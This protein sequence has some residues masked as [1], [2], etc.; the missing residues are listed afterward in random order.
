M[1][2]ASPAR[3]AAVRALER[4]QA[5]DA[6]ADVALECE[7]GGRG[8]GPRDAALATE[9]TFGT[10][11]WQRYL[12]WVLAP[13]SHRA[14]DTLDLR[15]RILLR[16]AAYQIVFLDR[17]PAF[18]AV[19]DAVTLAR[20]RAR[21]GIPEFVNAVLRAFARRG[22][23]EREPKLPPDPVEALATRWSYPTWLT[24]RL[25][26]R[27]GEDE[28]LALM[29]AMNERPPAT[30]RVNTLRT[31][32]EELIARLA[33]DEQLA[34]RP[35]R[36]APE[37]VTVEH[38]GAPAGWRSFA[39]GAFAVQDEASMLVSRLLGPRPGETVADVCAAPGTKT[40]HLAQLMGNTGHIV[41]FD[42]QPARLARVTEAS[43][44]LGVTIVETETGAVEE[45]A[46]A[47]TERCDAVL[48]D[49]PCSNLGVLRR[50]PDVKWRRKP[51]DI[52]EAARRQTV[53][54][55]AAATMVRT[56]GRLVYATCSLERE[57]ND[58]VVSAFLARRPDFARARPDG[59]PI[60]L[61]RDGVLRCLPHRHDTDGFTAV[62]LTRL[63]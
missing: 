11:R 5:D 32:R 16:L 35:G 41:A 24:A 29:R 26:E 49:A 4:V 62:L 56:G 42:P 63:P 30:L 57:E 2:A 9:L 10:L 25:I 44:R 6:F 33:R 8:L 51:A 31:T 18:A 46:S 54:L 36:W 3:A 43:A 1:S 22:S 34:A 40:T 17:V 55:A 47:W 38:G 37:G 23:R 20:E 53:I 45:Q 52:A 19:S 21:P 59:F 7:I 27:W 50:N 28:A 61:D 14:L 13:H 60:D 48:V 12:D 39:D 58:D 15:V